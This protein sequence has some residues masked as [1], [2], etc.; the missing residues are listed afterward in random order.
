MEL[1]NL[2]R[3]WLPS[4]LVDEPEGHS[5]REASFADEALDER[6]A[7]IG[8]GRGDGSAFADFDGFGRRPHL[9]LVATTSLS[10]EFDREH[11]PDADS[12]IVVELS[13][14]VHRTP[15]AGQGGVTPVLASAQN[16]KV[17]LSP[18]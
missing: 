4:P 12:D 15:T 3:G 9:P 16:E 2:E 13:D 17:I 10:L 5:T 7:E 11:F 1:V 8:I 18:G 6:G 14:D